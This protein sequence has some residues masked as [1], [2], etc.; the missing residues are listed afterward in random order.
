MEYNKLIK[1]KIYADMTDEEFDFCIKVE[2]EYYR[3]KVND[4]RNKN[5]PDYK[6]AAYIYDLWQ[7]YI[8]ADDVELA[9]AYN[10]SDEDWTKC[11]DYYWHE[12]NED[13]PLI[14]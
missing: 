13:N 4:L 6:I 3:D 9:D 10:I 14:D 1:E 5:I 8:I 11:L 7:D 2:I 12:M